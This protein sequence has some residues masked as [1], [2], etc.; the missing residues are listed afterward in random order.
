M[1]V[2][3]RNQE[4]LES[5][6]IMSIE[7]C[8]LL[9]RIKTKFCFLKIKFLYVQI[10]PTKQQQ[11]KSKQ[12]TSSTKQ[13]KAKTPTNL[14]TIEKQNKQNTRKVNITKKLRDKMVAMSQE[15]NMFP[16]HIRIKRQNPNV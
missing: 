8:Y 6:Y 9:F 12:A 2:K 15:E 10:K 4:T 11:Q 14:K 5:L 13:T 3:N 7:K 16:E 1:Q